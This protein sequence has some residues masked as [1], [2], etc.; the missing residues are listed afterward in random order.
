MQYLPS[1]AKLVLMKIGPGRARAL[2]AGGSGYD[3]K[4]FG[5]NNG[6]KSGDVIDT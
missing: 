3:A 5:N 4:L 6:N 2:E 1:L